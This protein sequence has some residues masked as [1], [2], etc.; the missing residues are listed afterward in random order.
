MIGDR[1]VMKY[2]SN[3]LRKHLSAAEAALANFS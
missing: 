2:D 1:V 3:F